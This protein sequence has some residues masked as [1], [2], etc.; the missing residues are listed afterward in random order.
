MPLSLTLVGF[1]N[2]DHLVSPE[3]AQ[4]LAI[5]ESGVLCGQYLIAQNSAFQT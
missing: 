4:C 5:R 3:A 2:E 1:F